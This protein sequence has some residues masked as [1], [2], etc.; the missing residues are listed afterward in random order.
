MIHTVNVFLPEAI[1][2][3]LSDQLDDNA[4]IPKIA[5][6]FHD[7]FRDQRN[8]YVAYTMQGSIQL[9]DVGTVDK[10]ILEKIPELSLDPKW[11]PSGKNIT[12][13]EW[14]I[15]DRTWDALVFTAQLITY[16]LAK[17]QKI[18]FACLDDFATIILGQAALTKVQKQIDKE[19]DD[20]AKAVYAEKKPAEKKITKKKR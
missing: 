5:Q 14:R 4:P 19:Y 20:E 9:P 16:K 13:C 12:K 2:I 18:K 11:R 15:G 10:T 17:T 6:F 1:Y 3:Q 7:A 8:T